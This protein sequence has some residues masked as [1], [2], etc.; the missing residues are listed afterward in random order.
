MTAL[1]HGALLLL[2]LVPGISRVGWT[3]QSPPD[4]A[5]YHV[6]PATRLVV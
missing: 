6:D 3:A 5:V 2:L 1:V 4:S